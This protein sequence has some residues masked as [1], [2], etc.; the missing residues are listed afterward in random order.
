MTTITEKKLT[1]SSGR[2]YDL[3]DTP[4]IDSILSSLVRY[5]SEERVKLPAKERRKVEDSISGAPLL[6]PKF[7][8]LDVTGETI[9]DIYSLETLMNRVRRHFE[10]YDLLLE[11]DILSP[12]VDSAGFPEKEVVK[13]S[14]D[15]FQYWSNLL[16]CADVALHT[17]FLKLYVANPCVNSNLLLT[18]KFLIENMEDDLLAKC[19]ETYEKYRPEEQGGPLLFLTMLNLLTT[20]NEQVASTH[21]THLRNLKLSDYD[22]ENILTLVSHMIRHLLKR[23]SAFECPDPSD[24]SKVMNRVLPHDFHRTLITLFETSSNPEFTQAFATLRGNAFAAQNPSTGELSTSQV[25][26]RAELLYKQLVAERRWNV[27]STPPIETAFTAC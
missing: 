10:E 7:K 22:G 9:A 11:F 16:T 5:S 17:R 13:G 23:L 25:L 3:R 14:A 4:A 26:D 21:L 18:Q 6:K 2:S 24:T 19:W 8:F 15:F 27:P 12:K 20:S 1:F